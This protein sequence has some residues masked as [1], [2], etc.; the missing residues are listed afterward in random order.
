MGSEGE[1]SSVKA[2]KVSLT[3]EPF[4]HL[5]PCEVEWLPTLD[6]VRAMREKME[7][8]TKWQAVSGGRTKG[9]VTRWY[10]P[11]LEEDEIYNDKSGINA[12]MTP[13]LAK[14]CEVYHPCFQCN[15]TSLGAIKTASKSSSQFDEH[16]HALHSD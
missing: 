14:L 16:N 9:K 12:F 6:E 7:S 2:M 13:L 8:F 1:R 5:K 11:E 15:V 3:R 10:A 4:L